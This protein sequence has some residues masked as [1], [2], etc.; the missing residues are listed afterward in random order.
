[1]YFDTRRPDYPTS[2]FNAIVAPRPIGWVST[3]GA[4]GRANLAPFSYFNGISATPP[5]VMFACNAPDDRKEK[6]TVT[7]A[8]VS[9]EFCVNLATFELREAMNMTSSTVPHGTDEF[10]LARLEKAACTV[11]ACPRVAASPAS[12]ECAVIRIIDIPP[13]GAGERACAVVIGRVLAVH[14]DDRFL[15]ASGRFDSALARPL[16]RLGG[17][18]YISVDSVFEIN[19]PPRIK[20]E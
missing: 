3:V 16:A 13:E 15:S 19:R 18:N 11:I 14:V 7:N 6:D 1:M 4:D 5:M 10:E 2:I 9:G 8:R 17:F 20:P 12:L